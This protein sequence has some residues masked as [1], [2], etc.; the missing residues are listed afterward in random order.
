MAAQSNP[1]EFRNEASVTDRVADAVEGVASKLG[2]AG[3]TGSAATGD[4][5][6][7]SGGVS[8][9]GGTGN[10]FDSSTSSSGPGDTHGEASLE[11][12][13]GLRQGTAHP[14]EKETAFESSSMFSGTAGTGGVQPLQRDSGGGG[15]GDFDDRGRGSSSLGTS[16]SAAD[17]GPVD[18][19]DAASRRASGEGVASDVTKRLAGTSDPFTS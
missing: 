14:A 2:L 8:M 11:E 16:G 13:A 4:E 10:R 6:R 17:M 3:V 9:T 19:L 1:L 12:L 5:V 7:E 15:R 18:P